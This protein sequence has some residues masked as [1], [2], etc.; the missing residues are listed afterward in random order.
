MKIEYWDTITKNVRQISTERNINVG[1][2]V[3]CI[4]EGHSIHYPQPLYF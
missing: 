2:F 3:D 1:K 4:I